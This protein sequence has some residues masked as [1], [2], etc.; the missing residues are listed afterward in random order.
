M[1]EWGDWNRALTLQ[2]KGKGMATPQRR[3]SCWALEPPFSSLSTRETAGG[4]QNMNQL[5]PWFSLMRREGSSK[6][7]RNRH[8]QS[9]QKRCHFYISEKWSGWARKCSQMP[10]FQFTILYKV[11]VWIPEM[12]IFHS[13]CV[14]EGIITYTSPLPPSQMVI[15]GI[16]SR[17]VFVPR[18]A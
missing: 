13:F 1:L 9:R 15:F 10:V 6:T 8:L 12:D 14:L 3:D 5:T 2:K 17:E 11:L 4:Q 7:G 18:S 16:G